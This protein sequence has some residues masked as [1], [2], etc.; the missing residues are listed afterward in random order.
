MIGNA[1]TLSSLPI[2]RRDLNFGGRSSTNADLAG[3]EWGVSSVTAK[4]SLSQFSS[5]EL[6]RVT[7]SSA[8]DNAYHDNKIIYLYFTN[9]RFLFTDKEKSSIIKCYIPVQSI[10]YYQGLKCGAMSKSES[11]KFYCLSY[12][13]LHRLLR[14]QYHTCS[15]LQQRYE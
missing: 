1:S 7:T 14:Q 3:E 6:S 11:L 13:Q 4:E 2:S 8:A 10:S 9:F 12:Q 5:K 15:V